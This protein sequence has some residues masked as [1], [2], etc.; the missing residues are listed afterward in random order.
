M[1][2]LADSK[3]TQETGKS[4]HSEIKLLLPALRM[5]TAAERALQP[6]LEPELQLPSQLEL[7][8]LKGKKKIPIWLEIHSLL[9]DPGLWTCTQ[10]ATGGDMVRWVTQ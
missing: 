2:S 8:S 5:L 3:N 6:A 10:T 9:H 4:Q 7:I 1:G